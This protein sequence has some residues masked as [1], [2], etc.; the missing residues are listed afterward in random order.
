MTSD[1]FFGGSSPE[2]VLGTSGF[3]LAFI[4]GLHLFEQALRGFIH[5]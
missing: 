4:D 1:Q 3:E 5:R 2:T